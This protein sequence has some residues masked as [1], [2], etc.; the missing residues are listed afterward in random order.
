MGTLQWKR[1]DGGALRTRRRSD[2]GGSLWE[3]SLLFSRLGGS[4]NV[5]SSPSEVRARAPTKNEFGSL[6]RVYTLEALILIILYYMFYA[7]NLKRKQN[8]AHCA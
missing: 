8:L 1:V 4:G 5:V 2:G 6:L 7:R 3:G